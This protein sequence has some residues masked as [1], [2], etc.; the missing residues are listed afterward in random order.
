MNPR[1]RC[2]ACGNWFTIKNQFDDPNIC[3]GCAEGVV[4]KQEQEQEKGEE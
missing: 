2:G 4:Q 3:S 1:R